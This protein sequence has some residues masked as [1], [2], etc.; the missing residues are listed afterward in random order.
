MAIR[1]K[2]FRIEECARKVVPRPASAEAT[3]TE[4]RHHEYLTELKALRA[5]IEP[6]A[7]LDREAIERSRAQ[8]AEAQAYKHELN[9]IYAAVRR[10]KQEMDTLDTGVLQEPQIARAGRELDAIVAGT[11]QATQTVLRAAE[12]IDRTARTLVD[13]LKNAHEQ[14]LAHDIQDRVVE[15]Y[16]ACNFQDLTGQRVDKVLA[17]LSFIELH[18]GRLM[19]IWHGIEQF[20]P[21]AFGQSD[22]GDC[23]YLNGPK[24]AGESGHSSQEDIDALFGTA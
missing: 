10:T 19:Q 2:V 13:T 5:L 21:V 9:L 16:E 11:E 6:Q 8:I 1:R 23:K 17:T 4:P 24:L 18:V 7:Q 14:G 20:K 15:I 22:Q 3:A 12:D